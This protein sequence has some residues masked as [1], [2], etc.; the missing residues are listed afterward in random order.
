MAIDIVGML[1]G[2]IVGVIITAPV[3]WIAGRL[4]VGP[5]KAKFTDA[6]VIV[7]LGNVANVI[8]GAF[9]GGLAGTLIQIVV[10]LFLIQK[11]YECSWGKA[12]LVAIVT[13]VIFVVIAFILAL[14]GFGIFGSMLPVQ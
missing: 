7:V 6:I 8:V 11:Y 13:V 2:V 10:Y 5:S 4:L 12:I 9:I 14:V 1:F 3:L